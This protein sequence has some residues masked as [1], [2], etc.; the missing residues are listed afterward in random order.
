MV[1]AFF[2]RLS[3]SFRPQGS[4]LPDLLTIHRAGIQGSLPL[5]P[6]TR[7]R[8]EI[9]LWR[10]SSAPRR[11]IGEGWKRK[12]PQV[13]RTN[14]QDTPPP[15]CSPLKNLSPNASLRRIDPKLEFRIP[16]RGVRRRTGYPDMGRGIS[17]CR[18]PTP[19]GLRP[20]LNDRARAKL[21]GQSSVDF[22]IRLDV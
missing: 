14:P 18:I 9:F 10:V 15:E 16:C 7:P 4:S 21:Y 1:D 11:P 19:P 12:N 22:S 3:L 6:K 5:C 13:C 8:A 20:W 17:G 2:L